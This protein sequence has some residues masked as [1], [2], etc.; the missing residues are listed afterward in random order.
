MDLLICSQ[1]LQPLNYVPS[2]VLC[3]NSLK[4]L[5]HRSSE[6]GGSPG[7]PL[8]YA[9]SC[10]I[11]ANFLLQLCYSASECGDFPCMFLRSTPEHAGL[12]NQGT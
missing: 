3:A 5:C 4:Q 8:S 6:C 7:M 12:L 10:T 1:P 2:C 11:F 9:S